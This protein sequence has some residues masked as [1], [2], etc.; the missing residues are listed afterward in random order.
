MIYVCGYIYI[1]IYSKCPH[2]YFYR[3]SII[4][5]Y[6]VDPVMYRSSS[7]RGSRSRR[8]SV[9]RPLAH[10][11]QTVSSRGCCLPNLACSAEHSSA[12]TRYLHVG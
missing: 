12:C 5:S 10:I 8:V 11:V 3:S 6:S 7:C 2:V 1:Y 9:D 4:R